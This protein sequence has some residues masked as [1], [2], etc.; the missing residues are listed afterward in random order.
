[1]CIMTLMML[2][3]TGCAEEKTDLDKVQECAAAFINNT[4]VVSDHESID[5][6]VPEG[7]FAMSDA[8]E[9]RILPY[10][11]QDMIEEVTANRLIWGITQ[12]ALIKGFDLSISNILFDQVRIEDDAAYMDYEIILLL[13][14]SDGSEEEVVK[15]GKFQLLLTDGVWKINHSKSNSYPI[16]MMSYEAR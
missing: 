5:D 2:L 9:E 4:Y 3:L 10:A 1:M 7:L 13:T 8:H 14:Y 15:K 11:T 12:S 16:L 6:S